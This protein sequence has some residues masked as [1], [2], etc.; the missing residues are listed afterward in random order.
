MGRAFVKLVEGSPV[1]DASQTKQTILHV[2]ETGTSGTEIY[3]GYF[4]E[5]YLAELRS[6]EVA[7]LW[8]KIRRSEP[9]VK[10]CLKA[11]KN[12]ILGANWSIQPAEGTNPA[13]QLHADLIQQVLFKDLAQSWNQ[14]LQEILTMLEFGYSVFEITHKLVTNDER[15]GT[16]QSLAKIALRV[17]KTI[18]R[19][20]LDPK[21]GKIL[22]VTQLANGD[23]QT[24][25]DLD[26]RFLLVFTNE[27]EGDNYEG[28]SALRPCYGA[29]KRK[30]MFLKLIAIG[31]EKGAVP[32]PYMEVPAGKENSPEFTNAKKVL[33]RYV[34][35]QQQYITYPQGW[36]L[37]FLTS[38]FDSSK[39]RNDV[40]RENAEMAVAFLANFL[41]LGQS[42]SGSWA[43]STDLSDFFLSS[44]ET[45]AKTICETFNRGLIPDLIKLNFGPQAAYPELTCSGIKDKAGKELAEILKM[46]I[47]GKA[48]IPDL[49]LEVALRKKYGLPKKGL[50]D[51]SRVTSPNP[52]VPALPGLAASEALFNSLRLDESPKTPK[53]LITKGSDE[54]RELMKTMLSD[55]GSQ[56]IA[57]LMAKKKR[58]NPSQYLSLT[59]QVEPKGSRD[60][61]KEL[62]GFL[63]N[64]STQSLRQARGEIPGGKKIKLV[65]DLE[66]VQ[67][68][69]DLYKKLPKSIQKSID[70]QVGL[71][72][73]FQIQD[74]LK[75][76]YFQFNSSVTST[77]SDDTVES[78]LQDSL[79]KFL[80]GSSVA[81]GAGN[82]VAKAVNESRSTF[83][84]DEDVQEEIESFTFV[85]GD[86]VSPICQ[87]LAGT[88]F[89]K[90]DPN[91]ERYSPPLHHNCK[92]YLVANLKGTN[93]DVDP[94]GLQPSKASLE[95]YITLSE[96][97]NWLSQLKKR[98]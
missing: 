44:L 92:S 39:L 95:K 74:L 75:A 2:Q 20:N 38:D 52:S 94:D 3:G 45:V 65:E 93:K 13:Y 48:I 56:V 78:D 79:D 16:Y 81:A 50:P 14:Q 67:L 6:R 7:E 46:L 60:Y 62:Q 49:D 29:W 11:V 64:L 53:A 12:P 31:S 37:G 41:E 89:S 8:D 66:S 69:E 86:P 9:K 43:L 96:W 28:I 83:F 61:K 88:V 59:S 72:T 84:F 15:F 51:P 32:T 85:N 55:V 24:Y 98:G 22:S 71:L 91:M 36:K 18:E 90:D 47:D 87:D 33:E 58:A 23:L 5:E 57:D 97:N 54:L 82:T 76:I 21:T 73:T 63:A 25:Q 4:Y 19:W 42:G 26:G 1:E 35:H 17:Q 10:M 40:E 27:K 77:D 30:N 34:S 68:D 80:E 70:S